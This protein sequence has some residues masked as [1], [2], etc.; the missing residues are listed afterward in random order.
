M[1]F[2]K[3]K[4][5][6]KFQYQSSLILI[7][8]KVF[9]SCKCDYI[10]LLCKLKRFNCFFIFVFCFLFYFSAFQFVWVIY[11]LNPELKLCRVLISGWFA[12]SKWFVSLIFCFT[13]GKHHRVAFSRKLYLQQIVLKLQFFHDICRGSSSSF[14][15]F[16]NFR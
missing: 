14:L 9:I 3:R 1:R 12:W 6:M 10:T 5:S 2:F 11:L 7:W 4:S 8:I 15:F 16:Q 13:E